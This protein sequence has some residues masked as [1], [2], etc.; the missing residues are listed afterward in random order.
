M[1]SLRNMLTI[2]RMGR[3]VKAV[4]HQEG[5]HL[6]PAEVA[7]HYGVT[8]DTVLRWARAGRLKGLRVVT[9]PSG[10]HRYV[11]EATEDE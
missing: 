9:L 3:M 4:D 2:L 8:T 1:S 11:K 7:R 5:D 10:Q 6:R